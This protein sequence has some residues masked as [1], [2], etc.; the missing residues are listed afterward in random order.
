MI[1]QRLL[2]RQGDETGTVECSAINRISIS[3]PPRL[4]DCHGRKGRENV[5]AVGMGTVL[6]NTV[7][8]V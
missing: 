3:L 7:F 1:L 2:H 6:E 5:R 4:R 8:R